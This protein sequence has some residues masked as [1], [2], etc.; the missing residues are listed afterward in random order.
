MIVFDFV[1]FVCECVYRT[2]HRRLRIHQLRDASGWFH[3]LRS[4]HA[5]FVCNRVSPLSHVPAGPNCGVFARVPG[6]TSPTRPRPRPPVCTCAS[7]HCTHPSHRAVGSSSGTL[8]TPGAHASPTTATRS[9]A[10][11]AAH[12]RR[13]RRSH[14]RSSTQHR[15][16]RHHG[17]GLMRPAEKQTSPADEGD[18]GLGSDP[19][20]ACAPGATTPIGQHGLPYSPRDLA[21]AS[22][23]DDPRARYIRVPS[24][25]LTTLAAAVGKV[26]VQ[27]LQQASPR[28]TRGGT[29]RSADN[30]RLHSSRSGH[31]PVLGS[32]GG[33]GRGRG[34]LLRD[35]VLTSSSCYAP[36]MPPA[37]SD[38]VLAG[39][40]DGMQRA[41][42][43]ACRA[44]QARG[45]GARRRRCDPTGTN[46]RDARGSCTGGSNVGQ[47]VADGGGETPPLA[48]RF[49]ELKVRVQWCGLCV[50]VC[51]SVCVCVCA[52]ICVPMCVVMCDGCS[53]LQLRRWR[54]FPSKCSP[55][56]KRCQARPTCRCRLC[57]AQRCSMCR[58]NVHDTFTTRCRHDGA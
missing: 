34:K 26:V 54:I 42:P 8:D 41:S 40:D 16:Q 30:A 57:D 9:Y 25:P 52:S 45:A 29:R 53:C 15:L 37:L 55:T 6:H 49:L 56:A 2:L 46:H 17:N 23:S 36:A 12:G 31:L 48:S 51:V 50:C 28:R 20:E 1:C 10:A 44:P 11:V 58:S 5:V 27:T 32:G 47:S 4:T 35:H 3:V 13:D 18:T 24:V 22:P 21:A 19:G 39:L 43:N 7:V 14:G 38:T 33:G